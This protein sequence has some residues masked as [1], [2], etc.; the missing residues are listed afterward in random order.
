MP[1]NYHFRPGAPQKGSRTLSSAYLTPPLASWYGFFSVGVHLRAARRPNFFPFLLPPVYES[2]SPPCLFLLAALVF[3]SLSLFLSRLTPQTSLPL[4]LRP[5]HSP[6]LC[7][8]RLATTFCR[9]FFASLLSLRM[10]GTATSLVVAGVVDATPETSVSA[11][12]ISRVPAARLIFRRRQDRNSRWIL[13]SR[14]EIHRAPI[15]GKLAALLSMGPA[16]ERLGDSRAM[17]LNVFKDAFPFFFLFFLA[18]YRDVARMN[19]SWQIL[20]RRKTRWVFCR[21]RIFDIFNISIMN[22]YYFT[23]MSAVSG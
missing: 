10:V 22:Y 14:D 15:R 1:T 19:R 12:G 8:V 3:K 18:A 11:A 20:Y 21:T 9:R 16:R 7:R 2:I 6:F 23:L 5:P 17:V 13:S 4:P